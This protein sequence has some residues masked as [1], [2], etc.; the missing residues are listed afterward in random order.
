MTDAACRQKEQMNTFSSVVVGLGKIGQGL[1]YDIADDSLVK[2]HAAGF[3]YHPG[4][5]LVAGVDP[6]RKQRER[7]EKKFHRPAFP[8]MRSLCSEYAPSVVSV[9]VPTHLHF[10]VVTEA[11]DCKPRAIICEKPFTGS[12]VHAQRVVALAR[13]NNCVLAVNYGRRSDPSVLQL[14]QFIRDGKVGNIYKGT[15]WYSKGLFNNG[16]HFIDLL[17]F[18]L[19]PVVDVHILNKGRR[20]GD[21]DP[22]PDMCLTF[23]SGKVYFFAA[24]DECYTFCNF[25]LVG[26]NGTIRYDNSGADVSLRYA[27]PHS[28]YAGYTVLGSER[29]QMSDCLKRFQ[30]HVFDNLYMHLSVGGELYSSGDSALETLRVIETICRLLD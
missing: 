8:D 30:W 20:L 6:G 13:E 17:V 29:E 27:G 25:E 2:T 1:D 19:G 5:E 11:F 22:E 16:S 21:S 15:G 4:F 3:L 7:F 10:P 24:R 18:L 14:R 26:T 23:Q 12:L 9:A 28:V